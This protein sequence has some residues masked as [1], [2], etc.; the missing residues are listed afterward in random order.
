MQRIGILSRPDTEPAWDLA[1][2]AAAWLGDQGVEVALDPGS[3]PA[4][5]PSPIEVRPDLMRWAELLLVLGGDGTL[6]HAVQAAGQA[7]LPILAVNLGRLGFLSDVDPDALFPA[8]E[9]VLDGDYQVE[10]RMLLAASLVR[11]PGANQGF[12][13]L[14]DV[15]VSKGALARM[16]GFTT[17]VD[18]AELGSFRADGLIVATPTG[19]TAYNLSAGGSIVAPNHSSILIT[20]ICPHA[21]GVRPVVVGPDATVDCVL[22]E[23]GGQ[24][25]LNLDGQEAVELREGDRVRVSRSPAVLRLVRTRGRDFFSLL[26]AKM[27]WG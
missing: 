4:G 22:D 16:I 27:R 3:V 19:S 25:W 24:A 23:S 5:A 26:R 1:R 18:G 12:T 9:R 17:F 6:L 13:A 10:E 7:G 8:I 21:L 20:P 15:V 14:N 11:G 2:R